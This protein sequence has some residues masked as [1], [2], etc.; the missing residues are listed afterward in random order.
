M[1]NLCVR[2]IVDSILLTMPF[3][4]GVSFIAQIKAGNIPWLALT[5]GLVFEAIQ[6]AISLIF[7]SLFRVIDINDLLLNTIG[8][9]LGYGVF[10]VFARA[11]LAITRHLQGAA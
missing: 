11:Y 8:V 2:N 5:V 9:L 7:K 4:F 1:P 6:L 10:M 3:G